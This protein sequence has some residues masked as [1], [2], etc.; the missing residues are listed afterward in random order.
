[1]RG[2]GPSLPAPSTFRDELLRYEHLAGQGDADA[3]LH[4]G[5]FFRN[6]LGVQQDFM[7]AFRW[8]RRSAAQGNADAQ[9]RLGVM[10]LE[11]VGVEQDKSQARAWLEKAASGG[12]SVAKQVLTEMDQKPSH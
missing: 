3:G 11:G 9:A 1:L 2:T 5:D 8:Y 7:E 4:L 6:G 10:Y 12:S